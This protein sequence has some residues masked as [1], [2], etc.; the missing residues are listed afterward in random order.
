LLK[1]SETVPRSPTYN[2]YG[3]IFRMVNNGLH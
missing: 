1:L 2:L 3:T